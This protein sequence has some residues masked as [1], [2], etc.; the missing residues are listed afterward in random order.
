MNERKDTNA[1]GGCGR[2]EELVS[3]LYGESNQ[4]ASQDFQ[5]HLQSCASCREEL[6]AFGGVRGS[7]AFWRDSLLASAPAPS[8]SESF[9]PAADVRPFVAAAPERSAL[10]ALRAFFSLSPLW[11][12][13]GTVAAALTFC[14]LA[15]LAFRTGGGERVV[16]QVVTKTVEVPAPPDEKQINALVEKRVMQELAA[17]LVARQKYDERTVINA[18][19]PPRKAAPR[20]PLAQSTTVRRKAAPAGRRNELFTEEAENLPRLSDLLSGSY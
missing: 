10:A 17:E 7:V 18:S 12:R 15:A 1:P 19:N 2:G 16:T 6:S 20:A 5:R 4:P 3:Y 8:L 11:L 13:A 14:A 9:A